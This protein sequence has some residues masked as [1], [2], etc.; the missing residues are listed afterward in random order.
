[1]TELYLCFTPYHILLN[2][3]I[4][5]NRNKTEDKEMIIVED[6]S[7][8]DKLIRGLKK[9]EQNPFKKHVIVKGKFSVQEIPEKSMMNVFKTNSVVSIL[10]EGIDTLEKRYSDLPFDHLFTCNDGRPQSQ[11]LQYICKKN[12]GLNVYV[13]DGS[14][15]YNDSIGPQLPFHESIFYKLYYGPW[16]ERIE[17]LGNYRYTD[18]IRALRPDLVRE[19]LKG[20]K[21]ESI[22]RESLLDLKRTGLTESI[23]N[24]FGS[25]L[26]SEETDVILFLP[27]SDFV[28][29][30]DLLS[31]YR[32]IVEMLVEQ[33]KKILLKYH[34]REKE[35]YLTE[36]DNSL[37]IPQSLPAE[38]LILQMIGDPP[39]IIGD[40]S[41]CLLTSKF[42]KEEIEVI[43]LIK[44][45]DMESK[46]LKKAFDQIGVK[47]PKNDY[48]LTE[49]LKD[50]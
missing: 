48:E 6:F 36:G 38:I 29:Q 34:P 28:K 7:D 17:V 49:I 9:W 47:M 11:V 25:D 14:E 24:E 19:E 40:V 32:N 37:A 20:K 1:M 46:N 8:A 33:N 41:T 31:L 13:E 30:K 5:L 42:L 22:N 12:N 23:L 44:I 16:H 21:I 4:A 27:H 3:S 45:I 43:S 10:K 18:E 35:H 26:T 39:I 2:S 50:V 15:L